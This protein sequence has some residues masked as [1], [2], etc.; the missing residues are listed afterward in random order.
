MT[1]SDPIPE[2]V[3]VQA[4]LV[5]IKN[6]PISVNISPDQTRRFPV[7]SCGG[8]KHIMA[9]VDYD[10]DSILAEPLTSLSETEILRAITKLY[11]H[12][13]VC[14]LQPHLN[15]LD[16]YC[17]ALMKY[18]IREAG[19]MRQLVPPGLHQSLIVKI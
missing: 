12:I 16:N 9:M 6:L 10:S 2:D 1:T 3:G 5:F 13:M 14:G 11:K 4:N 19:D 8:V 7:T 15:I 17:S 18:F